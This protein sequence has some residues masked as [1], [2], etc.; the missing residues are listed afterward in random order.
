MGE[1]VVQS[2]AQRAVESPV[3]IY[4]QVALPFGLHRDMNVLMDAE[5]FI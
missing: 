5:N 3:N 4:V 2:V 1:F